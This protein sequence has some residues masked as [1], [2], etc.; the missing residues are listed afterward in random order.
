MTQIQWYPGHMNKARNQLQDKINLID[1]LVE[2]LDA[3]IPQSSRNPL[4]EE[5]VGKKPHLI[6]LNKSDL[7]DPV[8]TKEWCQKLQT[9]NKSVIA[10]DSLH[11]NNMHFLLQMIRQ[12][13]HHHIR[14]LQARGVA[15][16]PVRIALA[17]IPNCGKSTLI[18]RLVGK[19]VA[20]VGNRPGVTK[21]QTWLKSGRN[22]QI[23]DTPGIL[24][25]KFSDQTVGLKLAAFG[26][27]KEGVFAADDVALF[28]LKQLRRYYLGYLTK[29]A[30]MSSDQ[31]EQLAAPDLLLA[32]TR[33]Y[34]MRDDYDRFA[35]L[36]LQRLA[37]GEI[38]RITLDR[39]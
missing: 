28:V 7:A 37:K 3:R 36:L 24:W 14:Q 31:V 19:N 1:V 8:L 27:I 39:P 2:V 17:G 13:A 26:A 9:P 20:R 30:R 11:T 12:T 5:L 21:G 33:L 23:L 25:P 34:G 15:H 32:L 4:I 38:G 18:N 10:L 22:I 16:P 6:V 35:H 29:Y